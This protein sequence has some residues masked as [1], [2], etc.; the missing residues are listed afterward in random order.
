VLDLIIAQG[1]PLSL[2]SMPDFSDSVNLS[3]LS[4]SRSVPFDQ[5]PA[6]PFQPGMPDVD[7]RRKPEETFAEVRRSAAGGVVILRPDRRVLLLPALPPSSNLTA[8][9]PPIIP[10]D[11]TCS[12]SAI[13]NMGFT[14]ASGDAVPSLQ[15]ASRAI[16]FLGFLLGWS[17]AGHRVWVFEG[18]PTALAAGLAESDYLLLD[19]G[20]LPFLQPDWMAVA[21]SAMNSGGHVFLHNRE[22]YQLSP[23]TASNKP[24]G[25]RLAEPDG[26]ASYVNCLLT[27]LAK[28]P[29]ESVTIEPGKPL[30]TL[31][32]LATDP[33][34][35]GWIAELPFQ[36]DRLH[37]Q[38]VIDIILDLCAKNRIDTSLQEWVLATKLVVQ[39]QEPRVQRFAFRRERKWLKMILHISKL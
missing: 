22:K 18:H 26:E 8:K 38:K 17:Q 21:K 23:L 30:P 13:T 37:A 10:L 2:S 28:G 7:I 32:Q 33:D 36:Y 14:M 35:L 31:A 12:I 39:N 3:G 19:S 20:M 5:T 4:H 27:T 24:P 9:L 15:D 1:L 11:R 25:W 16:P 34:E 6:D 29:A